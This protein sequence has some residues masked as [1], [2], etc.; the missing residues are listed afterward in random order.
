MEWKTK[1]LFLFILLPLHLV[2]QIDFQGTVMDNMS[3]GPEK[4]VIISVYEQETVV[5][6]TK[7]DVK[8]AYVLS[9]TNPENKTVVFRKMGFEDYEVAFNQLKENTYLVKTSQE[10]EFLE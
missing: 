4:N 9:I 2:A 6:Y 10:R 5:F 7:S 8:G 3:L 1:S